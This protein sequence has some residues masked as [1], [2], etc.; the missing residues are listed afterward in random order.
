MSFLLLLGVAEPRA[1]RAGAAR[2]RLASSAE[3]EIF[4]IL[5]STKR[6]WCRDYDLPIDPSTLTAEKGS[7]LKT[8]FYSLE[9]H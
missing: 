6:F 3:L 8:V 1:S 7:S 9:V 4:D 2:S 5:G